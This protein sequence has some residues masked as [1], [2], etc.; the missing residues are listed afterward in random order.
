MGKGEPVVRVAI[1]DGSDL[2]RI[3]TDAGF[4][5]TYPSR[6]GE[7]ES[8]IYVTDGRHYLVGDAPYIAPP[9]HDAT[10]P[11]RRVL[12]HWALQQAGL[13]GRAVDLITG[14]AFEE[15]FQPGT[16]RIND[17]WVQA[18]R[19]SQRIAVTAGDETDG[20]DIR[21]HQ[22]AAQGLAAY[23]QYMTDDNGEFRSDVR[24]EAPHAVIDIGATHTDCITVLQG[25]V[26]L[27]T[28]SSGSL[29]TGM[30]QVMEGLA[31]NVMT[32]F[33]VG[34]PDTETVRHI[35]ESGLLRCRGQAHDVASLIAR[36]AGDVV[37]DLRKALSGWLGDG[38]NVDAL[39][40]VGGGAALMH[41]AL[42][43]TYPHA[44][45]VT[46]PVTAHVHGMLKFLM[47]GGG[48]D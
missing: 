10:A 45:V 33:G 8:G 2:T 20:A 28:A 40:L 42:Q 21:R 15:Y 29:D 30:R 14:A 12:V 5:G 35:L 24:R 9:N 37:D 48:D 25:G 17:A 23:L 47:F 41:E 11:E 27:D 31:Q 22:V 26:E 16:S 1:D 13:A 18:R 4:V 32:T 43:R 3:I 46:D 19:E 34:R 36:A 38:R 39:L 44:V 6:V 7:S